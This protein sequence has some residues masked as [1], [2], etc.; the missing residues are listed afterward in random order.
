MAEVKLV[1]MFWFLVAHIFPASLSA[2]GP[3]R[4]NQKP[5]AA[6]GGEWVDRCEWNFGCSWFCLIPSCL[7]FG[8]RMYPAFSRSIN[9]ELFTLTWVWLVLDGKDC[10]SQ[11]KGYQVWESFPVVKALTKASKD[12]YS[13]MRHSTCFLVFPSSFWYQIPKFVFS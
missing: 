8:F 9:A 5:G 3:E 10:D 13:A 2:E 11:N 4:N 7:G 1:Q 6:L 12:V